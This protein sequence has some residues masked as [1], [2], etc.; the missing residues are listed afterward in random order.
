MLGLNGYFA[1]HKMPY[2]AAWML[3]G[4]KMISRIEKMLSLDIPVIMAIG[5]NF[6]LFWKKE[7]LSFY[8]KDGNGK[9][10][11]AVKTKA[12]FVTVTGI[13]ESELQ[14]S[15][16]GKKYYI[17]IQEY[18]KYVREHSSPLVS[19]IIYVVKYNKRRH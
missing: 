10:C 5:P 19:N 18:E 12:H 14:I 16:W 4:K 3:S 7:K 1:F 2:R 11:P 13:S 6:P 15:S 8:T 17:S 9:L